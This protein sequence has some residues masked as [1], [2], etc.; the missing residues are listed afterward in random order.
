MRNLD[1]CRCWRWTLCPCKV[2]NKFLVNFWNRT[3]LLCISCISL[4]Q[5]VQISSRA[6][7]APCSTHTRGLL[8]SVKLIICIRLVLTLEILGTVPRLSHVSSYRGAELSIGANLHLWIW[9]L[10]V[11]GCNKCSRFFLLSILLWNHVQIR[12]MNSFC[13]AAWLLV[14]GRIS[15]EN[16]AKRLITT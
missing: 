7:T 3:I 12:G 1:S 9:C 15:F 16:S 8:S 13:S 5:S 10:L 14:W 4:F 2:R 6:H 11:A